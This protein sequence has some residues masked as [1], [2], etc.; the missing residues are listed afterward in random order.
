MSTT[1]LHS[2]GRSRLAIMALLAWMVLTVAGLFPAA[3]Q[4]LS[5]R[6]AQAVRVVVQTQLAAFSAGDAERAFSFASPGIQERF[7]NAIDFM[8]MVL[9]SYP[10][11]VRP[12]AVAF[13]KPRSD[14]G[15]VVLP[16]QLR[17]QAGRSW[18][19]LYGLSREGK[20]PWRINGCVVTLNQDLPG[21]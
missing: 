11:V 13:Q 8:N 2:A 18:L 14:K 5:A 6:D 15:A 3:A 1:T 9:Q 19:A 21:T 12:A 10:M 20:G 7:G 4:T 17:D 16:V